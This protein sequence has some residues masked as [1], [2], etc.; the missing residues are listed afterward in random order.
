MQALGKL[1]GSR[2]PPTQ[3]VFQ[4]D[5]FDKFKHLDIIKDFGDINDSLLHELGHQFSIS[6]HDDHAI[7]F[8]MEKNEQSVPEVTVCIRVDVDLRV[9]LY[10]RGTP[11]PL[12]EWFRRGQRKLTSKSML[13]NFPAYVEQ[14]SLSCS[15]VLEELRKLKYQKSP[16]YSA[17]MI[18]YALLLRY[19][20]LQTYK[21]LQEEFKLPLSASLLR[22]I[23]ANNSE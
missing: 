19:T 3:C 13:H 12:P 18:R 21:L 8:K 22:R 7:F 16:L 15:G 1:V 9:C 2:K 14:K 23:T 17:N 4:E 10:H 6:R 11:I 20:S 5:E